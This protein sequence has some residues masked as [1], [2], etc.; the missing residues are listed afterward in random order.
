MAGTPGGIW[1]R[2]LGYVD[3]TT[4]KFFSDRILEVLASG[5]GMLAFDLSGTEFIWDAFLPFFLSVEGFAGLM[6]G[7]MA[8][9]GI[10]ARVD[11]RPLFDDLGREVR[12]VLERLRSGQPRKS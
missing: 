3:S 2:P 5:Y 9:L 4:W 10:Q 7:G 12:Q 1:V 6:G 11:P 8:F